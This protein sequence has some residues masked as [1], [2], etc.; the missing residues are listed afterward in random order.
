MDTIFSSN[1]AYL[2]IC[3]VSV[4]F[5]T[6][7]HSSPGLL[8][9]HADVG[10]GV[11]V[12]RRVLGARRWFACGTSPRASHPVKVVVLA[13]YYSTVV[14]FKIALKAP[15]WNMQNFPLCFN[16]WII[17]S[18]FNP[19]AGK[20]SGHTRQKPKGHAKSR[21]MCA[22]LIGQNNSH[23]SEPCR[24][25]LKTTWRQHT[26][27]RQTCIVNGRKTVQVASNDV[28]MRGDIVPNFGSGLSLSKSRHTQEKG[29]QAV[30]RLHDSF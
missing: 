14:R 22:L 26:T 30:S 11:E 5:S 4:R 28:T 2:P 6:C 24:Y 16:V 25:D 12:P 18:I 23:Q 20:F 19:L 3:S 29:G 9:R 17:G 10:A 1:Q 8:P 13:L 21:S 15:S 7:K 27:R